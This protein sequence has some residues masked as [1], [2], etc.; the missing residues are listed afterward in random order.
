MDKKIKKQV[1]NN[2]CHPGREMLESKT[3]EVI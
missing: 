3:G 1:R 2:L